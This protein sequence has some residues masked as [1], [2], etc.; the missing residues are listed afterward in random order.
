MNDLLLLQV[1][2]SSD[3]FEPFIFQNADRTSHLPEVRSLCVGFECFAV[4]TSLI[5][6][7]VDHFD[8]P[9]SFEFD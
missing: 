9:F 4:C 2:R 3:S 7:L 6:F 5:A 8:H 1:I